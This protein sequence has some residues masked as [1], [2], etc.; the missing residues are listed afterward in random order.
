MGYDP[1]VGSWIE[2]DPADYID[3][4]NRYQMERGNPGRYVD[5]SGLDGQL[6]DGVNP[7]GSGA[8]VGPISNDI[9]QLIQRERNAVPRSADSIAA[10]RDLIKKQSG[11]KCKLTIKSITYVGSEHVVKSVFT[12]RA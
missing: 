6:P 8:I 4:P 11:Y 7:P 3:G 12:D 10:L 5:P 1:T 9:L 2:A